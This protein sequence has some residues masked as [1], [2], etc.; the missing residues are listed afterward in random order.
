MKK[1]FIFLTSL[2]MASQLFSNEPPKT[3]HLS[4]NQWQLHGYNEELDLKESFDGTSLKI[5]WAW[6][7]KEF[8]W[9]SYS[10]QYSMR[11]A[12]SDGNHTIVDRVKPNQGFWLYSYEDIDVDLV[13]FNPI[14]IGYFDNLENIEVTTNKDLSLKVYSKLDED[15]K[16]EVIPKDNNIISANAQM[17]D[18][19]GDTIDGIDF[20]YSVNGLNVGQTS[21]EIKV[22]NFSSNDI[23]YT[24][25]INVNYVVNP[26]VC[27]SG[28]HFDATS[29]SCIT[30]T[31]TNT[32]N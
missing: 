31:E 12:L 24:K 19:S 1:S 5:L 13:E 29:N 18:F 23:N 28:M 6:D 25:T 17:N 30:D 8:K 7:N 16:V 10:P 3:L 20:H 9:V 32:T 21:L 14:E 11:V 15:L 26:L 27:E 22:T 4:G 2:A